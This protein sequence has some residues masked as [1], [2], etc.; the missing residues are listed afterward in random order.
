MLDAPGER[1]YA[2]NQ[3][4]DTITIFEVDRQ[5]GLLSPTGQVVPTGS[6]V[7]IVVSSQ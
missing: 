5:S 4:S 3:D 6:P 2:A 7:C 1:L